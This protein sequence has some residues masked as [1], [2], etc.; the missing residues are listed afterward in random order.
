LTETSIPETS[1]RGRGLARRILRVVARVVGV[2]VLL[3]LAAAALLLHDLDGRVR[4]GLVAA[5]ADGERA[6]GRAVT[7]GAVH[8]ALGSTAEIVVSDVVIAGA[9]GATG[10][11]AEPLLRVPTIRLGVRLEPLVRSWGKTIA[12]TR[13]E[14]EGPEITLV[15][16]A[17]GLS[18]DDVRA[19]VAALPPRPPPTSRPQIVLDTLGITAAKLHLRTASGGADAG[20]DVDPIT[21]RGVDVHPDA[22]SRFTLT[23]AIAPGAA[24]DATLELA[25][26]VDGAPGAAPTPRRV[27][28]HGAGVR[29]APILAWLR[30]PA[31]PSIDLADAELGLDFVV[32][33]GSARRRARQGHARPR[34]LRRRRRGR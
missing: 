13:F 23:A 33:P 6:I 19:R 5:A 7:I 10:I 24:L 22:A 4:E 17:E 28:I 11:L 31:A 3:A 12:V 21:L 1:P 29:V 30:A 16:T 9:A 15:R 8:V 14:V 26:P 32:D 20:L 18:I 34:A 27:T 25:P 2:V